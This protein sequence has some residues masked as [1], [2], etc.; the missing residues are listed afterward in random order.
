MCGACGGQ[1]VRARESVDGRRERFPALA[2]ARASSCSFVCYCKNYRCIYEGICSR[3]LCKNM[4]IMT[5]LYEILYRVEW[6]FKV[7]VEFDL[8]WDYVLDP[9]SLARIVVGSNRLILRHRGV[10]D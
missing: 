10:F 7:C 5:R 1:R 9:E 8:V 6:Y 4:G 3:E 2:G